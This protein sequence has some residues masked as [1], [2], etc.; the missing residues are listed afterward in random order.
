MLREWGQIRHWTGGNRDGAM[1]RWSSMLDLVLDARPTTK[2]RVPALPLDRFHLA[3]QVAKLAAEAGM[4]DLS[5]KAVREA[6]K[7]GPPVSATTLDPVGAPALRAVSRAGL[8]VVVTPSGAGSPSDPA[9]PTTTEVSTRLVELL[10]SWGRR[11]VSPAAIYEVLRD[12]VIPPARPNE[13]FLYGEIGRSLVKQALEAGKLDELRDLVDQR[14][15]RPTARLAA[16]QLSVRI[17]QAQAKK[18]Q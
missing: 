1:A 17:L 10:A 5:L 13:I 14:M 8:P 4:T 15:S 7:G 12:V 2:G 6:L 11:K 16:R 3:A 18:S 9:D